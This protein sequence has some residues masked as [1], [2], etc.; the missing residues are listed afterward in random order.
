MSVAKLDTS[1]ETVRA[2]S[3]L[4]SRSNAG[5]KWTI[6]VPQLLQSLLQVL[7]IVP[8]RFKADF[9]TEREKAKATTIRTINAAL[10]GKKTT[11]AVAE[12]VAEAA[13]EAAGV[14]VPE[15]QEQLHNL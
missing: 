1:S 6:A 4:E 7:E 12:A 9:R 2:C 15:G 8:K 10:E 13:A 3:S 14:C 5:L 11:G